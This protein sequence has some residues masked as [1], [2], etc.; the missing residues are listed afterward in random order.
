MTQDASNRENG[1]FEFSAARG[2]PFYELQARLKLLREDNLRSGWRA[3]L[4]VIVGWAIPFGL[5]VAAG[6]AASYLGDFSIWAKYV[7]AVGA[8]IL[9]E[10]R[11]DRGLRFCFLQFIRGQ[12]IPQQAFPATAK[13][14]AR[15]LKLRNSALAEAVCF[16]IA[17][18]ISL[19]GVLHLQ[20]LASPTWAVAIEAG[21]HKIAPAGWWT[22]TVSHPLFVFL[23]LR[24]LWRHFA[25]SRL[26]Q[27]ISR[28]ELRLVAAHPDHMAGLSFVARYPNFYVLFVF[29][30]SVAL[31]A[32]LIENFDT[33]EV[34]ATTLTAVMVG[35]LILPRPF[36]LSAVGLLQ[37]AGAA[38]GN[39]HPARF[40]GGDTLLAAIRAKDLRAQHRRQQRRGGAHRIGCCGSRKAF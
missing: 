36:P 6:E 20:S 10:A 33:V 12:L 25:W 31:A 27:A 21:R 3:F 38:Q 18:A 29:G 7:V 35:W 37:A 15:A 14:V 30:A 26:L 24:M 1:R 17:Y 28:I 19:L 22:L 13:A 2:G 32:G 9:A 40:P 34:S 11:V 5:C 8:F 4:F 39:N 16:V 23:F